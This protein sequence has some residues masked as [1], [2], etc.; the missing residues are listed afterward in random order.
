MTAKAVSKT[1]HRAVICL[2]SLQANPDALRFAERIIRA[3]GMQLILLMATHGKEEQA[4]AALERAQALLSTE[5]EA[6]VISPGELDAVLHNE[7]DPQQHE[8]IVLGASLDPSDRLAIAIA[9]RLASRETDSLLFIRNPPPSMAR[10]LI[11]SGGHAGSNYVIE[12]GLN[13][14]KA[15][16]TQATI[17]HVVS[18]MPSM[19]T[20][21]PA[22]QEG[23]TDILA[24][25]MPLSRHLREAARRAHDLGVQ[26]K[27]ELR[28]GV[29]AE[30]ILRACE[31]TPYD[32]IVMGAPEPGQV[33][34]RLALGEVAPEMLASAKVSLLI[35]R[36]A[37]SNPASA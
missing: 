29:V 7:L 4:Q 13:L 10:I 20:G 21:L 35:A 19:Y 25:D 3:L 32:L 18:S 23:L 16:E 28:H 30:E 14:A 37:P 2:G 11:C 8:L 33:L 15:L 17:L 12:R 24:R 36:T 9:R 22:V 5:P 6:M 34:E 26:A 31:V 1:K 27:L